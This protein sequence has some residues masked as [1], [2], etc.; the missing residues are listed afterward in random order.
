MKIFTTIF[1]FITIFLQTF[2]N[3][4][5]QAD[6]YMN[7]SYITENFC[8]NRDKPMMHC[9]G[10][11]YLTKKLKQQEKQDQQAPAAKNLK[12]DIQPFFIPDPLVFSQINATVKTNYFIKNVFTIASFPHVIF[13]PP[14]A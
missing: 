14:T 2:S 1:L 3:Y 7:R 4:I 12:F 9:N 11:C 5:I 8:I 13:H 10:K 6:F